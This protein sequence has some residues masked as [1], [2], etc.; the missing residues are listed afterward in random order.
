MQEA[1]VGSDRLSY[2]SP[3]A[4][5]LLLLDPLCPYY[6]AC[7][8]V[9]AQGVKVVRGLDAGLKRDHV[10]A[11][12]R[13]RYPGVVGSDGEGFYHPVLIDRVIGVKDGLI[14]FLHRGEI[15]TLV[16]ALGAGPAESVACDVG[17]GSLLPGEVGAWQLDGP[18]VQCRL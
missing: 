11:R 14:A 10:L 16:V 12:N 6:E 3:E 4:V 15:E 7:R 13:I 9:G 1:R 18:Q 2:E 17:I 8:P 5:C